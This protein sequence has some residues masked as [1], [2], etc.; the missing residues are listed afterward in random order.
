MGKKTRSNNMLPIET[1]FSF[2]DTQRQRVKRWKKIFQ[3]DGN[4][5]KSV[6]PILPSEKN[7]L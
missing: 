1:H 3:A 2:K 5:K 7:R 6:V 4:L